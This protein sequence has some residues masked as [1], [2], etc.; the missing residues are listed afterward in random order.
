M[1]TLVIGHTWDGAVLP[2]AR[3]AAVRLADAGTHLA[4]CVVAPFHDDPAP[5]HAVGATPGLWNHEV[6][7]LF[8]AGPDERYLE[9]ELG[10]YGHHLALELAGV[11]Q[12]F[13]QAM[14][15][16]TATRRSLGWW[17][18]TALIPR[19]WLPPP[20]HTANAFAIHGTADARSHA[21]ATPLPGPRPD[22][23]QPHRFPPTGLPVEHSGHDLVDGLAETLVALRGV[24]ARDARRIAAEVVDR[25]DPPSWT[26]AAL[27]A[28][29]AVSGD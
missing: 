4:M 1:T 14:P 23:H 13:R 10:P 26:V 3:R 9:V 6:V 2:A 15:M 19:A 11:R 28:V 24:P 17:A 27:T 29:H 7:E 22:F 5:D 8:V 18:G 16:Y 25:S 21:A 20:P 12:P